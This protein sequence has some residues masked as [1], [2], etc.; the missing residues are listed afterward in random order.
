M[1]W[2]KPICTLLGCGLLFSSTCERTVEL[3]I[4]EPPPRL[5]VS[6]SFTLGE[7]VKV[8]VSKSQY[9]L[10]SGL[11]E[12]IANA[13]VTLY[14]GED[15][16]EALGLYIDPAPR[17]PPYYV[18]QHFEPQPGNT[19]TVK[20]EAP[21]FATVMAHS[22]IPE[23]VPFSH[24]KVFDFTTEA[25]E[26]SFAVNYAYQ[27]R[28]NYDDPPSEDNY[29]H[30]N[31]FQAINDYTLG[32]SGDTIVLSTRLVRLPIAF[33]H[34]E[35]V[36]DLVIGGLLFKNNPSP[37]GFIF[38]IAISGIV[39]EFEYLGD[40]V[41][42]LRTVTREYYLYYS[43]FS[44]QQGQSDGP[45]NDPIVIFNNIENGHGYFA[46]YNAIKDSVSLGF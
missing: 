46:G 13:T 42:E 3:D 23:S 41:A 37:D 33:P 38:D 43:T 7:K 19:Y 17:I 16:I 22:Y 31:L 2:W 11:P 18:T 15:L 32:E 25:A 1:A 10:D 40:V 20:V 8:A 35:V 24:L 36:N 30:L 21:G 9:I 28:L 12:Y 44:R 5:V 14:E 39:P 34:P 4:E 6:S 45:F 27:V 29:Y 26:E